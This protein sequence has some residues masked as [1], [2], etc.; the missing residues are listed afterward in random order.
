MTADAPAG[1]WQVTAHSDVAG[2]LPIPQRGDAAAADW[3]AAGT[4]QLRAA[5]GERWEPAHEQVVPVLLGAALEHRAPEDALA[6]QVWPVAAAVCFF[7]HVAVGELGAGERMP[8]PG[9]GV[10]YDA[11]GLGLGI[12]LPIFD[13]V[14]GERVLGLQ[15]LFVG[16]GQAVS[17]VVEPTLGRLLT[18]LMPQ[19]HAFV[20]SI[21]LTAPDGSLFRAEPPALLEARPDESWVDSLTGP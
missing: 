5:W 13:E 17:V 19:V 8:G 9:D 1:T 10:L 16:E 21:R 2:W 3:I 6:F 20:Q 11:A 4:A 18:P 15:F 7:V 12:Q 14:A